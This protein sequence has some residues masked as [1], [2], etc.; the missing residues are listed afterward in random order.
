[1]CCWRASVHATFTELGFDV[2]DVEWAPPTT[3]ERPDPG[4]V[5]A[6]PVSP[7]KPS[8]AGVAVRFVGRAA[9][10]GAYAAGRRVRAAAGRFGR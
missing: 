4:A 7:S 10:A 5:A 9:R 3:A 1:V 6:R 8:M 2:V